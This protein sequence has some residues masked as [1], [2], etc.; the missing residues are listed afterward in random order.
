MLPATIHMEMTIISF[1][2]IMHL[3]K[4]WSRMYWH[5]FLLYITNGTSIL[6]SKHWSNTYFF[7]FWTPSTLTSNLICFQT[8]ITHS[9]HHNNT[10]AGS[11]YS[12]GTFHRNGQKDNTHIWIT[13]ANHTTN[14][15]LPV[16]SRNSSLRSGLWST[17]CDCNVVVQGILSGGGHDCQTYMSNDII[18]NNYGD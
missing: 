15:K 8:L 17:H 11:I 10:L 6:L 4:H 5:G 2:A 12:T 16:S 13:W 18:D 14:I 1:T 3:A 9:I 7:S